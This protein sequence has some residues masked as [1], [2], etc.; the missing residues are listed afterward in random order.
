M[1]IKFQT[2]RTLSSLVSSHA[3]LD[4]QI[5]SLINQSQYLAALKLFSPGTASKFTFLPL[6]KAC[7]FLSS[8]RYGKIIHSAAIVLGLQR[9]PFI[10]TSLI[11]FYVKCGSLG[12]AVEVFDSFSEREVLLKDVTIWN[13]VIDG[14]FRY[15][16][17]EEGVTRF[18]QMQSLGLRPDRYSL[19]ILLGICDSFLGSPEG[20]QIHGYITRNLLWG[21]AFLETALLHMYLSCGKINE[22][23]I[24]FDNLE[25]RSNV[26]L[27]NVMIGGFCQNGMWEHS[28][29]LYS[30]AKSENIGIVSASFSSALSA[31]CCGEC[32]DIGKQLHC[33][34]I[35]QG[36]HG[37]VNNGRAS[38]ALEVYCQMKLT[39]IFPDAITFSNIL[40][41]CSM[42]RLHNFGRSIH[43][44]LIKRSIQNTI[45]L[46]SSLL[47]MYS[48]CGSSE[49][50]LLIFC[51]MAEK[52]VVA[53]GSVISGLCHNRKY[54]KALEF[55][56]AMEDDALKPDSEILVSIVSSCV[57]MEDSNLGLV[58][59][60]FIIKSGHE[61]DFFV[62]ISLINMYSNFC[63]VEM[64]AKIFSYMLCK[65]LVAWNSLMSCYSKNDLP[66]ISITIFSQIVEQKLKPDSVSITTVLGTV[67]VLATLVKG[68][69]I[70]GYL[71][72]MGIPLNLQVENALIDM[73]LKCGCLKN[74]QA[75][76]R[77]MAHRSLVTWNSMIIGYGCHGDFFKALR[78]FDEMRSEGV[79]PDRISFLSLI[80]SC[81]HSGLV[82]EGLRIFHSM[83]SEHGIKP[84]ME[85]YVSIVDLLGR[86]GH[87]EEAYRF[88]QEMPN[89]SDRSVWVCLLSFCQVYGNIELGEIAASKILESESAEGSNFIPLLNLYGGAKLWDRGVNLRASM[90]E[91]GLKK[92]PGCSW[93][94]LKDSVDVFYS[95]DSSSQKGVQIYDALTHLCRNMEKKVVDYEIVEAY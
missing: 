43:A 35:K 7:T 22:A 46:Q 13:S 17:P 3:S 91:K 8:L 21:D 78:I 40:S 88:I 54:E 25:D 68:K 1:N 84:R 62:A 23:F 38:D 26:V 50:A 86:A 24:V 11:N 51:N 36:F 10:T 30:L 60:G 2:F 66:E 55:F 58:V 47:T 59:H 48:K 57:D 73:Y 34:V 76:F 80:S 41:A 33:D 52:D 83:R 19:S 61:L 4:S 79:I 90:K 72:R 75:I 77:N 5:K 32:A 70:H 93:I 15:G 69:A 14:Y 31:C 12:D 89:A 65:N 85:D 74:C 42:V 16:N 27:W 81:R 39:G 64:A 49:E 67:S 95:G 20:K 45:A 71:I 56:K 94:E 37:Y 18:R 9:D 53:W 6:L 44:E 29:E 63:S 28:L 87:L 82:K 92:N